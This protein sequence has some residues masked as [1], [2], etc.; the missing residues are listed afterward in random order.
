MWYKRST[1]RIFNNMV[2]NL[3]ESGS[4]RT[5]L[6]KWRS[7]TADKYEDASCETLE[8]IKRNETG[9]VAAV[10]ITTDEVADD[11]AV[12]RA[13]L[14]NRFGV[15]DD[16]IFSQKQNETKTN[17]YMNKQIRS[18]SFTHT[19]VVINLNESDIGESNDILI[20]NIPQMSLRL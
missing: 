3:R 18:L 19:A 17:L 20:E 5:L 11:I 4:A 6:T 12:L 16:R 10:G 15:D 14:I 2:S 1:Y 9:A 7:M 13:L 8:T